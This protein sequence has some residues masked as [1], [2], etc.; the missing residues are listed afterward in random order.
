[1]V[2]SVDGYQ[3]LKEVKSAKSWMFTIGGAFFENKFEGSF[4]EQIDKVVA[5]MNDE[6]KPCI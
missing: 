1:M 6:R 4:A 5:Y 3:R 2:G